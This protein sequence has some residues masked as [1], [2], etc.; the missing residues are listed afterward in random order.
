MYEEAYQALDL[1][2]SNISD[3]QYQYIKD[4]L[5]CFATLE[6]NLP[7]IEEALRSDILETREKCRFFKEHSGGLLAHVGDVSNNL[8]IG[9]TRDWIDSFFKLLADDGVQNNELF[10]KYFEEGTVCLEARTI[11]AGN[12]ITELLAGKYPSFSQKDDIVTILYEN[13]NVFMKNNKDFDPEQFKQFVFEPE[14][15]S[16][17]PGLKEFQAADGIINEEVIDQ[18][19]EN[20]GFI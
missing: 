12:Y 19:L 5:H 16:G 13:L 7:A 8:L 9:Q 4:N 10:S 14:L 1:A 17:N 18:F 6:K 3:K 15:E 2:K 11:V 20:E